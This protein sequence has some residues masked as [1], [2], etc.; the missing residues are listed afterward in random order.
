MPS[1]IHSASNSPETGL[2]KVV[3]YS[4]LLCIEG[5]STS[6]IVPYIA[7]TLGSQGYSGTAVGVMAGIPAAGILAVAM[8]APRM[9]ARVSAQQ[10]VTLA[11]AVSA[12]CTW[13]MWMSDSYWLWLALRFVRGFTCG[14]VFLIG[15]FSINHYVPERLRG[16][17]VAVYAG[18]FSI[19]LFIGPWALSGF[20]FHSGTPLVFV[21][22][23]LAATA[24]LH[25]WLCPRIDYRNSDQGGMSLRRFFGIAPMIA[26]G[27]IFGAFY[28]SNFL[29]FMPLYAH[30]RGY[31]QEA[32]LLVVSVIFLGDAAMQYP[33]GWLA[34]RVCRKRLQCWLAVVVLALAVPLPLL[35]AYPEALWPSLFVLG[36]ASGGIYTLS[37]VR[38]GE[39]FAGLMLIR[40]LANSGILWGI[41]AM[42]GPGLSGVSADLLGSEGFIYCLVAV[43]AA[44]LLLA[45]LERAGVK[46]G[47]AQAR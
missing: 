4:G 15:E 19:S 16:R 45:P 27:I 40:A 41:S 13:A 32:A 26:A 6:F 34:D 9:V 12:L 47:R 10:L 8:L 28:E 29:S 1:P 24:Q 42:A 20:D 39:S 38:M 33:I 35:F 44:L 5:F 22:A 23:V 25:H 37:L 18:A 17:A 3:L 7:L 2:P 21:G 11:L 43:A 14:F 36:A 46:G 31:A 30:E